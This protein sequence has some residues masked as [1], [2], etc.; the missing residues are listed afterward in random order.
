[1]PSDAEDLLGNTEA[2]G[3]DEPHLR[4]RA[5]RADEECRTGC[6]A[7]ARTWYEGWT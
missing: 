6:V 5:L 3:S 4:D 2:A 7:P 1:M